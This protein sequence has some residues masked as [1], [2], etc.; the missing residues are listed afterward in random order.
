MG[1]LS[2]CHIDVGWQAGV[3]QM[4]LH[5]GGLVDL[6]VTCLLII[7][8]IKDMS[9]TPSWMGPGPYKKGLRIKE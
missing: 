6:C 8:I 1:F 5:Y 4:L 7:I 9:G 2:Q 3:H